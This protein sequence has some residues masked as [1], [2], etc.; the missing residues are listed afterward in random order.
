M[1]VYILFFVVVSIGSLEQRRSRKKITSFSKKTTV[2]SCVIGH[3]ESMLRSICFQRKTFERF[4]DEKNCHF[5]VS[6]AI[7]YYWIP[8]LRKLI[9]HKL[10][11]TKVKRFRKLVHTFSLVTFGTK[12]VEINKSSFQTLPSYNTKNDVHYPFLKLFIVVW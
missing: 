11:I 3:S 2:T 9:Y 6:R 5:Y 10:K 1:L 4:S 7:L 12:F 8:P